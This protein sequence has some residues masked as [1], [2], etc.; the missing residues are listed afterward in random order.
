MN[1]ANE[2]DNNDANDCGVRMMARGDQ[3]AEQFIMRASE[4]S[5]AWMM[6]YYAND[7]R[8]ESNNCCARHHD[9]AK[10]ASNT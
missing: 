10:R 1:Y 5:H 6:N 9:R 3:H 4:K 2:R 8:D 7:E